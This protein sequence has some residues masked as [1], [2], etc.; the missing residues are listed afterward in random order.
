MV[1]FLI[2]RLF[3]AVTVLLAVSVVTFLL[4]FLVPSLTGSD[5]ASLFAG[6]ETSPAALAGIRAKLGF[7]HP[8]YRQYLDYIGG[9]FHSRTFG[10]GASQTSCPWPCFGYSFKNDRPVWQII[11]ER[12]PVTLSLV[13]G[14]PI[15]WLITGTLIG[16]ISALKPRSIFDRATMMFALAAISLPVYFTGRVMNLFV[17]YKWHWLDPVTFHN[18]TESP[19]L[20]FQ[21]LILPWLSLVFLFAAGYARF[22]RASMM[23]TLSEDYIRTARAKGLPERVVIAKHALRAV[24]TVILT[25]FGLDVALLLG[26]AILTES[27]FSFEGIGKT[28]VESLDAHDLPITMGITILGALF[29]V[30]A[31]VVVDMLYAVIDPRVRV[32]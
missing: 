8:L 30:I 20:W 27:T 14:A 18:F 23:D 13:V 4:F 32:S 10:S 11:T 2:R 7:D 21:N 29:V 26:G 31:N 16:M 15:L 24:L 5:P 12:F 3:Q 28:A 1:A 22:V 19:V 17:V 6:R 9:F 25:L